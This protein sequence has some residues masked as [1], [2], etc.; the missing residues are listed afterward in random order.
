MNQFSH[1]GAPIAQL[2]EHGTLDP[3][4]AGSILTRGTVLCP[5]ARHF[6]LMHQSFVSTAP[7][8]LG[9]SGAFNFS[10]FK[11]PLKALHSGAKLVVKSLLKAPAP[12]GT[13]NNEEQQR[14]ES[15]EL[16]F[17]AYPIVIPHKLWL[18]LSSDFREKFEHIH[19]HR[20]IDTFSRKP[21]VLNICTCP[22]IL[23]Y[24]TQHLRVVPDK[25]K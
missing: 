14:H 2:G 15:F 5:G 20:H 3:K 13:D 1:G 7:S 4:V 10:I 6:I 19:I 23:V 21:S 8:G 17:L 24:Q 18:H 12:S 25:N 22:Y 11:A 9:I 16:T